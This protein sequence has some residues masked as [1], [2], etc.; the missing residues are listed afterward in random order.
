MQLLPHAR[1]AESGKGGE[2]GGGEVAGNGLFD[3][4]A[5]RSFEI[6][7]QSLDYSLGINASEKSFMKAPP[8]SPTRTRG[9]PNGNSH[10]GSGGGGGRGGG[11]FIEAA[12]VGSWNGS[13]IPVATG[14]YSAGRLMSSSKARRDESQATTTPTPGGSKLHTFPTRSP[15]KFTTANEPTTPHS[16]NHHHHHSHNNSSHG[17]PGGGGGGDSSNTSM[18]VDAPTLYKQIRDTITAAEF[19]D[20]AANVAA[21]NSSEQSADDT[22]R[23]IGRLVK[24]RTLFA[25]MRFV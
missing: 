16:V 22:V 11:G 3:D 21:F 7:S 20:F 9:F 2:Y 14:E 23:N 25:Q 18:T 10:H 8:F 19:E 15:S 1:G 17:S 6:S 24:D 13:S 5:L 4:Q 12:D